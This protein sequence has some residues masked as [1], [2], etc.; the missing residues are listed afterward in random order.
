MTITFAEVLA[1][2]TAREPDQGRYP[3]GSAWFNEEED[4]GRLG[5]PFDQAVRALPLA[6]GEP[7]PGKYTFPGLDVERATCWDRG[8]RM[9]YAVLA[10]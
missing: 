10:W 6:H 1:R 4:Y 9:V 2:I 7:V 8:D 3:V 5:Q